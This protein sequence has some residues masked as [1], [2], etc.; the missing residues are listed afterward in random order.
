MTGNL[1]KYS[2][3]LDEE[4][5]EFARREFVTHLHAIQFYGLGDKVITRMAYEAGAV[6]KLGKSMRINRLIL[7]EY[8]RK[9]PYVRARME[10]G[11]GPIYYSD[12]SVFEGVD[13]YDDEGEYEGE[14]DD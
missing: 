11:Y 14:N 5:I 10:R 3:E 8:M 12:K 9:N 6:Y 7:E 13:D 4:D 1:W 2:G